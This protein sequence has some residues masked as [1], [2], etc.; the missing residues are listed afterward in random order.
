MTIN[1][2]P[3]LE[4]ALAEAARRQG[5]TPE[6]LAVEYLRERFL[7]TDTSDSADAETFTLADFLAGHIGVL[8]SGEHVPGGAGLSEDSGSRF[9]AG[10]RRGR[11]Q[12]RL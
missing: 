4:R 3:D 2:T 10:L 5:T 1:L 9:T 11:E 12:G 8:G 6:R 7:E